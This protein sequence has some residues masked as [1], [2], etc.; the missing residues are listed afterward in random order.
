MTKK[1]T[2]SFLAFLFMSWTADA[3][4][5]DTTYWRRSFNTGLSINQAAFSSNWSAGGIN[6]I[7]LNALLNLRADY[8][9]DRHSW[10]NQVDFLYGFV[11]N[12]GQGY[13]KTNDR[14]FL[15]TKYGYALSSKWDMFTSVSFL[16][17]FAPGYRYDTD[18]G[19][20]ET[21]VRISSFMTP[22][23]LTLAWGFEYKPADFFRLR[24]SPVAPRLTFAFDEDALAN[25]PTRYGV[26]PGKNIRTEW[27][28]AQ[29]MADFNK[30]LNENI[31]LKWRYIMFAGF[32]NFSFETIDHRLDALL[33]AKL[34]KYLDVK[35]NLILLYDK[36]QAEGI[37]V[38]QSLGIGLAY[39]I[40]NY[41]E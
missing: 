28:A 35:L 33:T 27:L 19:G 20:V 14:L 10:D 37:Q 6:S 17:Q 39:S 23:F 13:R 8:R 22:G 12:A 2:F 40:Q 1:I 3:Q 4:D 34:I 29:I 38:S 24:L 26:D 30:D 32:D 41:K 16:S 5:S 15:D 18:A 21:E 11:N 7:G 31:N 9:K 36:D 25:V